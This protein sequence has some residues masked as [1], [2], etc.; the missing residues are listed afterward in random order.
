[1]T[2]F[3]RTRI[4]LSL[5]LGLFVLTASAMAEVTYD[6]AAGTFTGYGTYSEAVDA[7]INLT[8]TPTNHQE[9]DP[10]T[11]ET[12]TIPL[13]FTKNI[14]ST[15]NFTQN[16][17]NLVFG[18]GT[19]NSFNALYI[20]NGSGNGA[21]MTLSGSMTLAELHV[22]NTKTTNL[23]ITDGASLSVSGK[24]WVNEAKNAQGNITQTGGTVSFTT[25]GGTD[26]R[27]GHWP[28]T[29]YPSRYN[30][31][32]GSLSIPNT[33]TYLGWDGRAEMNISGGEVSLKGL[34]ISNSANGRGVFT[35]KGGTF[36]IGDGGVV[37]NKRGVSGPAA[38]EVYLGQGTIHA[39]DTQTWGSN[40]SMSL[41]GRSADDT[42]DV[43]GGVTTF[44]VDEGKTITIPSVISG[45]GA[46]TKTGAGTLTLSGANTY[47]GATTISAGTLELSGNG[48]LGTGAVTDSGT[49]KFNY[50]EDKTLANAITGTG[51]IIKEGSNTVKLNS[52]VSYEGNMTINGG[53]VSL[54]SNGTNTFKLKNLSGSGDLEVRLAG[55]TSGYGTYLS[56]L[57]N[58]GFTGYISLVQEGSANGNKIATGGSTYQ[59]FKFKVNDGTSIFVNG[60]FKAD[61]YISG[62]GNYENRGAIRFYNNYSGNII[63]VADANI[64]FDGNR[65]LSGSITSGAA[66]GETTLFINGKTD[67][68]TVTKNA[69]AGTYTGAVSDGNSGGK[70]GLRIVSNT[71]TFSGNLSYTGAT[72]VNAGTTM[73]L[74]GANAN[75]VNSRAA[76]IDGKL[77][78][79]SYTGSSAMQL[80]DLSGTTAAAEILGTDKNLILNNNNDTSYAGAIRIGSGSF[81]KTGTGT[82]TL[83]GI[84]AY[85]GATTVSA[86]T[87]DLAGKDAI[88]TSS[89]V[90]NNAAITASEDQTFRN[91]SGAGS[92]TM[93][94][95]DVTLVSPAGSA[96][97]GT[98]SGVNTLTVEANSVYDLSGATVSAAN[99]ETKTGAS[100]SVSSEK[101]VT[102]TNSFRQGN[103]AN[104]AISGGSAS[105][106]GENV[107]QQATI[108][109][110]GGTMSINTYDFTAPALPQI[111]SLAVHLD[112][113]DASSFDNSSSI[114]TWKNLANP[115]NSLTFLGYGGSTSHAYVTEA[116]QNGLN[117]MTFPAN[118]TA[119][120]NMASVVNGK[121]FFAVMADNGFTASNG[122]SF[123]FGN[124]SNGSVNGHN[125]Y[126]FH[127]GAGT[128]LWNTGHL[129]GNIKTSGVTSL[130]GTAVA[131]AD[132][133]IGTD[134]N[135][136]TIQATGDVP[137]SAISR[138]RTNLTEARGWRG[139]IA[140]I[141]VYTDILTDAQVQ[142]VNQY[143]A[144][145]WNVGND[146]VTPTVVTTGDFVS[147]NEI[148]IVADSTI[149]VAEFSSVTFGSTSINE[150]KTL[151][152]NVA[153]G[154]ETVWTSP[155]SGD[156]SFAKSGLGSLTLSEVPDYAGATT[157]ESGTLTLPEG[158]TL[159]NLSGGSLN[160]D[161]TIAQSAVLDAT[162][163][164]LTF[165]NSDTTKFVG[166]IKANNLVVDGGGTL[167]IYTGADGKV[168]VQ[169]LT[170]SSGKLDVKGY[171]TGGIVVESGTVFSPGN[172]VGESTFG[173][174][175]TLEDA[176]TLL[177]EQDATGMDKLTASSYFIDPNSILEL[178][179]E[180]AAPGATYAIIVQKDGDNP[181]NFEDDLATDIFWNS[182]LTPESD[183]YWNLSVVNNVVY[184]TMD[185]NAVPEPST[186]ALLALGVVVLFLRKR[187]R[188]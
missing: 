82:L 53:A 13:T 137:V 166:S 11:G 113:S 16:G 157:V 186:W 33:T 92:I 93:S 120:Y 66:S 31:S 106:S 174:S 19:V 12:V 128:V 56:S 161:G 39:T 162:G 156:G 163:K 49:L 80:N 18:A 188:S 176:A 144:T 169:T 175:F 71:H 70:L 74:S 67:G 134:W 132:A 187:V 164:D 38:A 178:T 30:I 159:N 124:N 36:N 110:N 65:T 135:V 68:T 183:Y 96:Y 123:L 46:L 59:G 97:S 55:G 90:V 136:L 167:Q 154:Q 155:I 72:T 17:E 85:S 48:T 99:F 86:G 180:A 121:T 148:I 8:A 146:I 21:R 108:G 5:V 27:I 26:V 103:A 131:H 7:T 87:L 184:A 58:D 118:G 91:L 152:I 89:A 112:A 126:C 47:T 29:G 2:S 35:L 160:P 133:N 150:G 105:I 43:A 51:T 23:D 104:Y 83:S 182:L 109:L 130:N 171:M 122:Y 140:E 45:V 34:S 44:D 78:F 20:N 138:E 127:R 62:N 79:S 84:V 9:I 179:A 14:V 145:K 181:V 25:S 98:I 64:G 119:Y 15:G 107:A 139:D 61:S 142:E 50:S 151:T 115:S 6:S 22:A 88:A 177:I 40:L 158:G 143:L 116:G 117:V 28:N 147:T 32:G 141:L 52:A 63:V 69:S 111:S 76:A 57:I 73:N 173:G 170:V 81:T 102:V 75:L 77:N 101:P 1:M 60:D 185:S 10:D 3:Q 37:R 165:V 125:P 41:Y 95:K 168:D 94:N 54:Y 24:A 153:E 129:D 100:V 114:T 4:L 172:S 149:D 42:A